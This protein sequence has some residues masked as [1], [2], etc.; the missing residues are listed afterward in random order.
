MRNE[1]KNARPVILP[2]RRK[3]MAVTIG[4][5]LGILLAGVVAVPCGYAGMFCA[6]FGIAAFLRS[7]SRKSFLPKPICFLPKLF[8]ILI[9]VLMLQS[10][11]TLLL[12]SPDIFRRKFRLHWKIR[13]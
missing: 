11:L 6:L 12:F 1:S 3:L 4:Y 10:D 8:L 5:L 2:V 7:R 13:K 9:R